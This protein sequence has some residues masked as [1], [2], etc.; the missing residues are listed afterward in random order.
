MDSSFIDVVKDNLF[1]VFVGYKRPTFCRLYFPPTDGRTN[2]IILEYGLDRTV[3]GVFEISDVSHYRLL[4][5]NGLPA[6]YQGS[7]LE[8]PH[9]NYHTK[10]WSGRKLSKE[11]R[12]AV[13]NPCR[14]QLTNT[15]LGYYNKAHWKAL[16]N[17]QSYRDL[18]PAMK[19]LLPQWLLEHYDSVR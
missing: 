18:K 2:P 9:T 13:L 16:A 5:L 14:Q 8:K 3:S 6:E 12:I 7:Y 4:D 1:E 10:D 19:L 15:G 11:E 17:K